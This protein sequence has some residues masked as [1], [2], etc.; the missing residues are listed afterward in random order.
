MADKWD[1]KAAELLPCLWASHGG[2]PLSIKRGVSCECATCNRRPA[3]A[4]ELRRMAAEHCKDCC[5]AQ[6]WAALGITDYTGMSIPEHITAMRA[7]IE[8]LR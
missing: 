4:A 6:S 2:N 3:V 8:R 1:E 7:E 5:C